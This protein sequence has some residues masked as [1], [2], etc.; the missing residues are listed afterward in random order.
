MAG[1]RLFGAGTRVLAVLVLVVS[2]G[3]VARPAEAAA[4]PVFS[5][6]DF[7]FSEG[8]GR[9][10]TAAFLDAM[11]EF[12]GDRKPIIRL[13]LNW[14]GVEGCKGCPLQWDQLDAVVDAAAA[15]GIRVLLILNYAP[16]WAN[17]HPGDTTWFPTDD[18]DW[19]RIVA[20]TVARYTGKIQAYE[21]WNEPNLLH[22]GKYGNNTSA[23][24]KARYWQL[25]RIAHQR[26]KAGCPDCVVLAGGSAYGTPSTPQLNENE[27]AAWLEWGYAN[28]YRGSFDAVAHHP[29]PSAFSGFGPS[30]PE[31]VTRWW[32][33]FGPDDERCGELAAVRAVMVRNGDSA[34]KIWGTEWGYPTA[35]FDTGLTLTQIRD[36]VIEGVDMWRKLSYTGPLILYSYRDQSTLDGQPCGPSSATPD[37]HFGIAYADGRPKEPIYADL[38]TKVTEQWPSGLRSGQVLRRWSALRSPDGR[39]HLWLHGDGNLAMYQA[40]RAAPIWSTNTRGAV[41]LINQDDGNLVLYSADWRSLWHT[42]TWDRGPSSLWMQSDGNLVLYDDS[43]VQATWSSWDGRHY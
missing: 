42:N 1:L 12:V 23:E 26:V 41:I 40:G 13:D 10:D 6:A 14:W 28:G 3:W 43:P 19:S 21:V 17:G 38:R 36:Y 29:Y 27:P 9:T 25:V 20:A 22:F 24:R 2:V 8:G 34:K 11:D 15:R 39:F 31:C 37:C 7:G 4:A 5:S 32:N 18:A 33:M 35:G 16:P 30:R